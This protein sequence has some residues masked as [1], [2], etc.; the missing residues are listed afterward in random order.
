MLTNQIKVVV[1]ITDT[2][3]PIDFRILAAEIAKSLMKERLKNDER[4]E[5]SRTIKR[6]R[7]NI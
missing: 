5:I 1:E 2:Q 3:K 7:A 6:S 4:A